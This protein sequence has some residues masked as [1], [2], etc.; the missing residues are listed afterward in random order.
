MIFP[1]DKNHIKKEDTTVE[2]EKPRV[3]LVQQAGARLASFQFRRSQGRLIRCRRSHRGRDLKTKD[4]AIYHT[5]YFIS[6]NKEFLKKYPKKETMKVEFINTRVEK[7]K[8]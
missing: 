1:S 2:M 7:V 6:E 3:F 8:L 5:V 4:G